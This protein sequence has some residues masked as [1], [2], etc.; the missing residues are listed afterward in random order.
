MTLAK[1]DNPLAPT[2]NLMSWLSK[3]GR[4]DIEDLEQ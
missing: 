4:E 2:S 3:V 1:P